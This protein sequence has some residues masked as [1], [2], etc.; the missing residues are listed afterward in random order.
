MIQVLGY[1]YLSQVS[2]YFI[3]VEILRYLILSVRLYFC[4]CGSGS[5][6]L[7]CLSP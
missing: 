7:V 6:L 5:L 2:L 4:P 1:K 3:K